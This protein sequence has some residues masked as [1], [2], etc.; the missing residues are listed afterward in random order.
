MNSSQYQYSISIEVKGFH[1]F[2]W[3]LLLKDSL[4]LPKFRRWIHPCLHKAK[5]AAFLIMF[6]LNTTLAVCFLLTV[7]AC[8]AFHIS[9]WNWIVRFKAAMFAVEEIQDSSALILKLPTY[10]ILKKNTG[11]NQLKYNKNVKTQMSPRLKGNPFLH[12]CKI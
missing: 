5:F 10:L 12:M 8:K 6:C 9:S 4:H 2:S 3:N 1:Y 11:A 7:C